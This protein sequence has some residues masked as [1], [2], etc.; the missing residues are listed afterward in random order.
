MM[1]CVWIYKLSRNPEELEYSIK[2]AKNIEH[3]RLIVVGDNHDQ[4]AEHFK[5][6][7]NR[8]SMLSLVHDVINK[9]R[10]ACTLDISDE[11]YLWNDD[12]FVLEPTQIPVA[13]RG[14]LEN[15][16]E[17]RKINDGYSK[18]LKK[19]L[20]YLRS[21]GIKDPLSYE[22]H[23]PML[24]NKQKLTDLLNDLVPRIEHSS[25]IL[26]RSLYGNLYNIGGIQMDDVKTV[27]SFKGLK[28]L[29]SNEKTFA[30]KHGDYVKSLV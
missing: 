4:P 6:P 10:F 25:P 1:D 19:T 9:L 16:I 20:E 13:H 30:G 27:D 22:L 17:N 3:G 23:I 15:H 7:I 12:F 2:S 26:P 28:F 14:T 29:S 18:H 21:I 24:F 5:P 11:F 8:W